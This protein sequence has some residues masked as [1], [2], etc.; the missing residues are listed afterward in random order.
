MLDSNKGLKDICRWGTGQK[1]Q[2]SS[3]DPWSKSQLFIYLRCTRNIHKTGVSRWSHHGY[4]L[5][6]QLT[7]TKCRERA[8]YKWCQRQRIE[9][10][11]RKS[12]LILFMP[13][14]FLCLSILFHLCKLTVYRKKKKTTYVL[15]VQ[16]GFQNFYTSHRIITG[17]CK[18]QTTVFHQALSET[19]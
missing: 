2:D 17:D 12:H 10:K 14:P 5:S 1:M 3:H 6:W 18:L 19:A 13:V 8:R 4:S 11:P 16:N 7:F 15:D 9:E